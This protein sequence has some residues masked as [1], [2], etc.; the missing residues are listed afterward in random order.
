MEFPFGHH[1]H[2]RDD[3]GG[4]EFPPPGRRPPPSAYDEPPPS[5]VTH[6]YHTSHVGGPPPMDPNY[7]RP[8]YPP[9]PPMEDDYG[10]TSYPPPSMEDS[11]GRTNYPPPRMEENYG[12]SYNRTPP[13]YEGPPPPQPPSYS[14]VE[15]V[16]H[17]SESESVHRQHDHHRFQP[18]VPSFFHHETS[19]HPE[20]ID[21]PSFRVYTKADPNYSLTIRDGKVVLAS[22]D[23]SDPFQHW[24]KDEKYS[25]KVKDE[26]GFPSFALV[27]KAAG[28]AMKHSVGASH[29]V[30]L[31]PYDPDVL[32]ASVLW[33]ESR[34]V[35]DGYRAV[36]MVNNIR[37]NLDA[38]NAD[39]EHGGVR[40]GTIVAL[41]E[42]WKG[43]NRNQQWKIVPYC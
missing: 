13:Y 38:W 25:T 19:P 41:W 24:Y 6:V 39:K 30:Q 29:P 3:D 23:P 22:S 8:H 27:N 42:W 15:H 16:S 34:D 26:E 1:H 40:D 28:L 20:L 32:D 12:G 37:L 18:H 4:E 35:S 33:T 43:D 17:E 31:T 14:S 36:R 10:R 5:E 7:N 21:K 2:R 11:Y 9:P